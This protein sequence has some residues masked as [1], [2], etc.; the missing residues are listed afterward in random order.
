MIILKLVKNKNVL[1]QRSQNWSP[2]TLFETSSPESDMAAK[3]GNGVDKEDIVDQF[4]P[5]YLF[6]FNVIA[7]IVD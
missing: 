6:Y 5:A 4:I 2:Y 7:D 3:V 1:R